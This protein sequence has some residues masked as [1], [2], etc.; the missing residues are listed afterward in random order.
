MLKELIPELG[1]HLNLELGWWGE[2]EYFG[3]STLFELLHK[4]S[5]YTQKFRLSHVKV[6]WD[7]NRDCYVSFEISGHREKV[8]LFPWADEKALRSLDNLTR[9]L[10]RLNSISTK[11]NLG[12]QLFIDTSYGFRVF[13]VPNGYIQSAVSE[14]KSINTAQPTSDLTTFDWKRPYPNIYDLVPRDK[15]DVVYCFDDDGGRRSVNKFTECVSKDIPGFTMDLH[16]SEGKEID[17][18]VF[19]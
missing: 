9:I 13:E 18:A 15:V 16:A 17:Q 12:S 19:R 7:Y 14:L 10:D 1:L 5:I 4:I 8:K 11:E 2:G 3:Q 6:K